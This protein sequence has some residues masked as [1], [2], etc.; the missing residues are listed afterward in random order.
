M[1]PARRIPLY[2]Y[3]SEG[4]ADDDWGCVWRSYQ[5]ALAHTGWP[6]VPSLLQLM[7]A[8]GARPPQWAEPALLP[9]LGRTRA[10]L[11]GSPVRRDMFRYTREAQYPRRFATCAAFAARLQPGHAY[12]VDD[13]VSGYAVVPCPRTPGK[14]WWVDPHTHH[15][16]RDA[17]VAARLQQSPGWMVL[18]VWPPEQRAR[19]TQTS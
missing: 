10:F 15:P 1:P 3:G 2:S 18:E 5:N 13:G 14:H 11:A 9:A 4:F 8:A 16:R 7:R 6:R 19:H 12:V 17:A